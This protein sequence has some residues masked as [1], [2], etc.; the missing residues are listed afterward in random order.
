V[1]L[2][3]TSGKSK[4]SFMADFKEM[5][6]MKIVSQARWGKKWED[7]RELQ[8]GLTLC[9]KKPCPQGDHSNQIIETHYLRRHESGGT[10]ELEMVEE[11]HDRPY[12]EYFTVH[13]KWVFG[14]I[15]GK[16]GCSWSVSVELRFKVSNQ[17]A[18]LLEASTLKGLRKD[19]E[20]S[21]DL[22]M[23]FLATNARVLGVPCFCAAQYGIQQLKCFISRIL[24]L[25][26]G[27]AA[28]ACN[29]DSAKELQD[30]VPFPHCDSKE[31]VGF[32]NF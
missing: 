31:L 22:A 7:S 5:Q 18:W 28:S 14:P 29:R 19:Y 6:G 3:L 20:F 24:P 10:V 12:N 13:H 26:L 25:S 8:R 32:R 17:L 15:V 16:F 30:D 11:L 1:K 21:G 9:A 4:S 23:E 2:V 27:M